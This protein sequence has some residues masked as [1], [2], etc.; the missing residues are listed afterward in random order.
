MEV[1]DAPVTSSIGKGDISLFLVGS[2]PC[3]LCTL[4]VETYVKSP[5]RGYRDFIIIDYERIENDIK[6]V[7][8]SIELNTITEPRSI[9]WILHP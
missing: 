6:S 1:E 5:Y 3:L 2:I 4:C 8:R 9:N 7:S